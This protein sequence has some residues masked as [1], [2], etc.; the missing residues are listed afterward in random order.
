MVL[1]H[2]REKCRISRFYVLTKAEETDRQYIIRVIV[3]S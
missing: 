1:S 2:Y 3:A